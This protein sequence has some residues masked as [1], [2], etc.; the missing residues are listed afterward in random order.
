MNNYDLSENRWKIYAGSLISLF[1]LLL[2]LKWTLTPTFIDIYYHLAV[3][4][5]FNQAGGFTTQAFWE[6]APFG[7]PHLYP[8]LTHFLMLIFYKLNLSAVNVARLFE[9]LIYPTTLITFWWVIKRLFSARLAFFVILISLSIYSFYLSVINF[10]PTSLAV[11]LALA[12]LVLLEKGKILASFI[13]LGLTFY[14]HAGVSWFFLVSF[15]LYSLI[16]RNISRDCLK[17]VFFSFIMALPILIYQFI[18]REYLSLKN[19][20]ERFPLE[21]NLWLLILFIPGLFISFKRKEKY[22]FFIALFIASLLSMFTR[23]RYR[24]ICG[25]GILS[26][27]FFS[28]VSLDMAYE[29]IISILAKRQAK[30]NIALSLLIFILFT[31]LIVSPAILIKN[32]KVSFHLFSSTYI[33]LFST[34]Q[35]PER[36]HEFSIFFPK[37]YEPIKDIIIKNSDPDDIIY[38][39][40]DYIAGIFSV[41]TGRSIS[42][43]ML[44]E[45]SAFRNFDPIAVSKIIIWI[46][47]PDKPIEKNLNFLVEK[48]KLKRIEE[49]DIAYVYENQKAMAKRILPKPLL[50]NKAVFFIL[51]L[52]AGLVVLDIIKK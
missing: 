5:G 43:S 20:L 24:F 51:F 48:Y 30:K 3:M 36:P 18:F 10:I 47:N 13:F 17:V 39:N 6:Y 23:Y 50:S 49:T 33:G 19:V 16:N 1:F 27:I 34:V 15:I 44:R 2:L 4:L 37:F 12:S 45:V 28:S 22:G 35:E 46:K 31:L 41:L 8:A 52:L 11:I 32:K 14:T 38:C 29:R 7:R 26:L 21:I 9:L 40:L 42:V 25:Q